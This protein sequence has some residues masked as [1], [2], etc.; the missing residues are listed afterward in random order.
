M[1]WFERQFGLISL[2]FVVPV[3][4]WLVVVGSHEHQDPRMLHGGAWRGSGMKAVKLQVGLD[5]YWLAWSSCLWLV[6]VS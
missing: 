2:G 6:V 4:L 3:C 5:F 1:R